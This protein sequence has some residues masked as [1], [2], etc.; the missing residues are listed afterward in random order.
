MRVVQ[1]VDVKSE[2]PTKEVNCETGNVVKAKYSGE[3]WALIRNDKRRQALVNKGLLKNGVN[4]NTHKVI[5]H[6]I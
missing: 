2:W 5:I 1:L 6:N 3:K 4:R